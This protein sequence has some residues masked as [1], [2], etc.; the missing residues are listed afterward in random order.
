L[1]G[2]EIELDRRITDATGL[3]I[4]GDKKLALCADGAFSLVSDSRTAT[5]TGNVEPGEEPGQ[6]SY[7]N[8]ELVSAPFDQLAG[9]GALQAAYDG[10]RTFAAACYAIQ[11]DAGL[12]AVLGSAALTFRL[13]EDGV[14]AQVR[15][16]SRFTT[17]DGLTYQFTDGG[18]D[19]L[20][21]HYTVGLP[22]GRLGEGLAWIMKKTRDDAEDEDDHPIT[23]ARRASRAADAARELF[24]RWALYRNV[25]VTPQE[26]AALGGYVALFYTQLAA[27]IDH[28]YPGNTQ[29]KNKTIVVCRVP[30]RRVAQALPANVQQF[31]QEQAWVDLLNEHQVATGQLQA[32][33]T[34]CARDAA[35]R[36]EQRKEAYKAAMAELERL[37]A[38]VTATEKRLG[39]IGAALGN[40]RAGTV[41]V[42]LKAQ[43]EALIRSLSTR[44]EEM[45]KQR[46]IIADVE[47]F[48]QASNAWTALRDNPPAASAALDGERTRGA[49]RW[50]ILDHAIVPALEGKLPAPDLTAGEPSELFLHA[51]EPMDKDNATG[52]DGGPWRELATETVSDLGG[53]K[54]KLGEFLFSA[55]LA[56]CQRVIGPYLIFGGMHEVEAPDVY[57]APNGTIYNLIPLELRSYGS[58]EVTW[59]ELAAGLQEI[60]DYASSLLS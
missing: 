1:I 27:A 48:Q 32:F 53:T 55:L 17:A 54:I 56:P 51:D 41:N 12:Q 57:K 18:E 8:I 19:S 30:L 26:A 23:N 37:S 49:F 39:T 16:Q 21:V 59:T 14:G 38:D 58:Q 40:T 50:S 5:Q 25:G 4:P 42:E 7:S 43:Q 6:I 34:K 3:K 35:K 29:I 24:R 52:P 10:M 33:V 13:T 36:V 45:N 20:F 11:A 46:D 28:S 9:D 2:F 31:L 22:L 15:A 47:L 60:G 44:Q